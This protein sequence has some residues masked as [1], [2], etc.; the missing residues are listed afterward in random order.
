MKKLLITFLLLFSSLISFA[1][2]KDIK[3]EIITEKL[4]K[5]AKLGKELD[6]HNI[7]YGNIPL[8]PFICR[9]KETPL[10]IT[11]RFG[12]RLHPV[13]GIILLHCGID[14]IVNKNEPIMASGSG[15]IV[16]VQYSK[17]G[18]GNHIIIKHNDTYSTLYGHLDDILV[19]KGDYIKEGTIIGLGG[20]TGL[21]WGKNCHLHFELRKNGIPIDPF[22]FI[23]AKNSKEFEAKINQLKEIKD[24]L[25][26]IELIRETGS[27]VII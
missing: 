6:I 22:T 15:E 21:V 24:N 3:Q 14:V 5:V 18:Y 23:G 26:G 12:D 16:K 8:N 10:I 13:L 1:P 2:T 27:L 11:S 4:E 17:Y 20:R 25:F 7:G 19:K 9:N